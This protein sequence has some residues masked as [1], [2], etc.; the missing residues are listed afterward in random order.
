MG[1]LKRLKP[2][3]GNE[4]TTERLNLARAHADIGAGYTTVVD[5][6]RIFEGLV[7]AR[8]WCS[9]GFC[10]EP[11]WDFPAEQTSLREAAARASDQATYPALM[12]GVG[13]RLRDVMQQLQGGSGLDR[14]D[15][16]AAHDGL[17]AL[18][19]GRLWAIAQTA[20]TQREPQ[21]SAEISS[22]PQPQGSRR[23]QEIAKSLG[24]HGYRGGYPYDVQSLAINVFN[25]GRWKAWDVLL[26]NGFLGV[27]P[28]MA[29][30]FIMV[31]IDDRAKELQV[32]TPT[33]LT[34]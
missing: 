5:E 23:A 17:T 8:V 10:A 31:A 9:K 25:W 29:L 13:R 18:I 32:P 22:W 4:P 12:N 3:V 19:R 20:A 24:V 28:A 15:C 2:Q 14:R 30:P 6:L 27:D 1:F 7:V 21:L 34:Q 33:P 16:D 26:E 11:Q